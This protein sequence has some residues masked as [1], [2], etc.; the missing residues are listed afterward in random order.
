MAFVGGNG[1]TRRGGRIDVFDRELG[2][3]IRK[4]LGIA[5]KGDLSDKTIKKIIALA[6]TEIGKWIVENPEGYY[7][8]AG[9]KTMGVLAPS[10][11]LPR[12]YRENLEETVEMIKTLEISEYRRQIL[13]KKYNHDIG[14]RIDF[15]K[16]ATLGEVI[17]QLN[18]HT[19]FYTY[20]IMWFN[21][22]NC[23][24]KKAKAFT[25]SPMR[26]INKEFS[27]KIFSG[28]DYFEWSPKDFH[29]KK[30]KPE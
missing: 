6:N 8:K 5:K 20:R 9:N 26:W 17:P 3:R 21:S 23:E 12:E 28:K 19:Y 29:M 14:R 22:K 1:V 10:K 24:A 4:R 27:E 7:L 11:F 13:L 30:I 18:L 16:L 15:G 2:D 25:F